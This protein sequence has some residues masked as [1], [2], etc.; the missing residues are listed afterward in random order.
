ML[1][2]PQLALDSAEHL[3]ESDRDPL[4]GIAE[5]A[6]YAG[7]L[8]RDVVVPAVVDATE[9]VARRRGRLILGVTVSLGVLAAVIWWMRRSDS[10]DDT[11]VDEPVAPPR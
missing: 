5:A 6:R 8:A 3:V 11:G 2:T 7:D 9:E 1:L 10:P 4:D